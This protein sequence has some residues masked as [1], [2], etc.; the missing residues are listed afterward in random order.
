MKIYT[1]TGDKGET[2]LLGGARVPKHHIR[3]ESYGTLDE[4]NSFLG[5]LRDTPGT[6]SHIDAIIRIQEQLFTI[7]SHLAM[8]PGN[9]SSALPA[10]DGNEITFLEQEIDAMTAELP[11]M[12]NFILPGGS[13]AVSVCHVARCVCRR[14]ERLVV[15]L[16]E[17]EKVDEEL[18]R[19]LNRLSDYLFVLARLLGKET[20]SNEIPWKPRG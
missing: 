7:G 1:R 16:Q 6:A 11:E 3:I 20:N 10:F 13:Q 17:S 19:Y 5:L 2:G 12:R 18:V 8:E 9:T 15:Q 14:A 4:L